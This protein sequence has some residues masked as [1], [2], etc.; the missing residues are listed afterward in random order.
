M[1]EELFCGAG[2]ALV[3]PFNAAGELD[4]AMLE[5]LI[6]HQLTNHIDALIL[7]GTTGE[8]AT[9]SIQEKLEI[10]RIG[11]RLCKGRIPVIAGVGSNDTRRT[12]ELAKAAAECGV[13]G[14]LVVTP[15][16]NKTTQNGAIQHFEAVA[17]ATAL[18]ILLYNVPSRTGLDL[19]VETIKTLSAHPQIIGIKEACGSMEKCAQIL[20]HCPSDFALYSG[21]DADTL[22]I[23]ALGGKGVISVSS[24]LVPNVVHSI[25]AA[26]LSKNIGSAQKWN[27]LL[28][29]LNALLF[30]KVNPLPVKQLMQA[31]GLPC[32]SC[33]LPLEQMTPLQQEA[34]LRRAEPILAQLLS[35]A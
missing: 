31:V 27:R 2:T 8:S 15:Y 26:A 29:P 33:R 10:F 12:V 13:D 18:P 7:C 9:L 35:D 21:N 17:G 19:S 25:C 20:Y 32:G 16:Y 4:T 22:P 5:R 14:L 24:N 34:L 6:D 3:T 23:L 1:K 30:E 11:V 28:T